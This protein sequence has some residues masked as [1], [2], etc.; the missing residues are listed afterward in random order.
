MHQTTLT[1]RGYELDSYGHVNNAVYMN[2]MEHARWEM[3]RDL[4]LLEPLQHE[5]YLVVVT[6]ASIRYQKE[7]LL[8]DVLTVTTRC[9]KEPPYLVFEHRIVRARDQVALARGRI[10]TVV[11]D[12]EKKVN[13]IPALLDKVFN[14]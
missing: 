2:Y 5:G 14:L 6:E 4:G 11:L 3:F 8:A 1:V 9:R 12:N 10:K 7:A 13:D